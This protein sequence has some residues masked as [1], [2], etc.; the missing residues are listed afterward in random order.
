MVRQNRGGAVLVGG[1]G[2]GVG[3][4]QSVKVWDSFTCAAG[5]RLCL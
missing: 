5:A 1:G 4:I 2:V 3:G